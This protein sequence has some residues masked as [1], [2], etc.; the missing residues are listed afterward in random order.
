MTPTQ[1]TRPSIRTV[2]AASTQLAALA[3]LIFASRSVI[4]DWNHV[5]TGSMKPTIVEGD[6]IFVNKL[7]Y[8]LKIPF[9]TWRVARWGEPQ[10]GDIVVLFS[11]HNG[12]R[13]VK[14]VVGLPGDEIAMVNER[15]IINGA[16]VEYAPSSYPAD[17]RAIPVVVLTERLDTVDHAIM[18]RPTQPAPRSFAPVRVPHG[19]Y[20]VLGDNRDNSSDSRYFGFVP[21]EQIVGRAVGVV[22]SL[23]PQDHFLPRG[24][25][26]VVGIN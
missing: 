26:F 14:R 5:P 16:P 21:R 3:L 23:D 20:L 1:T 22:L 7:A 15:L 2:V 6:V 11:P 24:E 8:D 18:V 19:E 10:R 17:E 25:R 12:D 9:T 13:L 4:A